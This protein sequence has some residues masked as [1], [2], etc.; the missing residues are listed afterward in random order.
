MK[1]IGYFLFVLLI[2]DVVLADDSKSPD[3][4]WDDD[5]EERALAVNEGDLVFLAPPFSENVLHSENTITINEASLDTGWVA[6]EQ[7]YR[8]LDPFIKVDVVYQYKQMKDLRVI[9]H[10][11]IDKAVV[12]E[13]SVQLE[14]VSRKASL[15][16][17][18]DVRVFYTNSDKS[19]SLING[20]YFRKFLHGYYPYHVSFVINYPEDLIVFK[21][22]VPHQQEGFDVENKG[23]KL[24]INAWFEGALMTEVRFTNR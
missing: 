6:I 9:S 4:W 1:K 8:N 13:N 3:V 23:N 16:V 14:G 5:S 10:D 15:C 12:V 21:E 22:T 2:S 20:P 18:A 11:G 17:Q 24:F 7:C 19:F